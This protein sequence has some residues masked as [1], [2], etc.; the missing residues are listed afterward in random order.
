[1]SHQLMS[2]TVTDSQKNN[3]LSAPIMETNVVVANFFCLGYG[4][5]RVETFDTD[6]VEHRRSDACYES[7]SWDSAPARIIVIV[8]SNAHTRDYLKQ[9]WS[10]KALI[11][12]I[13]DRIPCNNLVS[14]FRFAIHRSQLQSSPHSYFSIVLQACGSTYR[15]SWLMTSEPSDSAEGH[16][17]RFLC[18][19]SS[20]VELLCFNCQIVMI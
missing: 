4:T 9:L 13:W 7:Y 19:A 18:R 11:C 15:L 14:L 16:H 6:P 3:S 1:M 8:Y 5:R 17:P 12:W 10:L 20:G 2:E